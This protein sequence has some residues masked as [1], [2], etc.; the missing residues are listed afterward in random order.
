MAEPGEEGVVTE[1][2]LD[3]AVSALKQRGLPLEG[4]VLDG[5]IREHPH[6]TI[7]ILLLV[8]GAYGLSLL[9]ARD[10]VELAYWP[11]IQASKQWIQEQVDRIRRDALP[12]DEVL[13]DS[14]KGGSGLT[15]WEPTGLVERGQV[16]AQAFEMTFPSAIDAIIS[17]M[18]GRTKP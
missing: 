4:E 5:L 15:A 14:L 16:V 10:V 6:D 12:L 13:L 8:R 3:A 11:D 17:M 7:S 2:E 9:E 18:R 1:P